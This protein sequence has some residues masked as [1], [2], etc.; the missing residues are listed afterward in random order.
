ME[1][2]PMSRVL[3]IV[4]NHG[5]LAGEANGTYLPEVTHA[6]HEL[7]GANVEFDFASPLGGQAPIYGEDADEITRTLFADPD[8]SKALS[9]TAVLKDVGLSRYDAIFFPGGYGLL[10]DLVDNADSHRTVNAMLERGAPVS[11]VC[12]GPAA[13]GRITIADGTPLVAGR[14]VTGFTREEEVD[15]GTI[16]KVPF[17][18]EE[19][20][21]DSGATYQKR[22][23]WDEFVIE[24]GNIITGQNPGSAGAVGRSLVARLT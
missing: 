10:F 9:E 1:G 12:H 19:L 11:A 20:M 18:L 6:V 7:H 21:M 24:D 3:I 17:L 5:E 2:P 14:N 8:F 16:D 22:K 23:A 4:T 15:Y 13:L